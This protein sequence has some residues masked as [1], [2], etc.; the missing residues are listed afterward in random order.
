MTSL[1]LPQSFDRRTEALLRQMATPT[2]HINRVYLRHVQDRSLLTAREAQE[3]LGEDVVL[4]LR[5]DRVKAFTVVNGEKAAMADF[6]V[7]N[8]VTFRVDNDARA[9]SNREEGP[10]P[11]GRSVHAWLEG[12]LVSISDGGDVP[13]DNVWCPVGYHP[14]RNRS[15]VCLQSGTPVLEC[16]EVRLVPLKVKVWCPRQEVTR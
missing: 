7:L 8:D 13:E 2:Q 4:F 10:L 9:A 1:Q 11:N 12:R 14:H 16:S 5:H 15:F 6:V 3:W